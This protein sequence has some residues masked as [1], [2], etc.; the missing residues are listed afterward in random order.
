MIEAITELHLGTSP[1]PNPF[2]EKARD[3]VRAEFES[4]VQSRYAKPGWS[5]MKVTRGWATEILG[6]RWMYAEPLC[7]NSMGQTVYE[8]RYYSYCGRESW[9]S[10]SSIEIDEHLGGG[11][12]PGMGDFSA[13]SHNPAAPR[14]PPLKTAIQNYRLLVNFRRKILWHDFRQKLFVINNQ[15][16][17]C[18][19]YWSKIFS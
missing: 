2:R 13:S 15:G 14:S 8:P 7:V 16:G 18:S 12:I 5:E 19:I 4:K 6:F 10:P 3:S 9:L 17:L 1:W 11:F